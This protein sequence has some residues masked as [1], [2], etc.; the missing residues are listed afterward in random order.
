M[1]ANETAKEIMQEICMGLAER[2]ETCYLIAAEMAV[3]ALEKQTPKEPA[4]TVQKDDVRIGNA[5]WKSGTKVHMCMNCY[6]WV[7]PSWTFCAECGQ[8]LKWGE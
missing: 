6:K 8:A 1:N 3:S 4:M 2:P 5:I 7:S